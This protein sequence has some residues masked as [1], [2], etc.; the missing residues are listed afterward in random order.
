[1]AGTGA[2]E[3]LGVRDGRLWGS[4]EGLM[5]GW[6]RTGQSSKAGGRRVGSR[7]RQAHAAS[8]KHPAT[9]SQQPS[10]RD[11]A[12]SRGPQLGLAQMLPPACA[13]PNP[14]THP[15]LKVSAQSSISLQPSS[16]LSCMRNTAAS[17]CM[18]FCMSRRM[19]AVDSG[20]VV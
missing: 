20:P 3:A 9:S 1:M 15:T 17:V 6:A 19:W 13:T 16:R 14:T 7:Q 18:I 10:F 8:Q 4:R 11:R 5:D 2:G 12:G